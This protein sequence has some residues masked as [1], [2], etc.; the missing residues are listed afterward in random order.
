MQKWSPK[1][2]EKLVEKSDPGATLNALARKYLLIDV[3]SKKS[4]N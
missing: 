1:G 4:D 2:R 3:S